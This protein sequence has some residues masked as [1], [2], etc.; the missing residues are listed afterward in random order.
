MILGY[1]YF[2][3]PPLLY[4]ESA[5]IGVNA[6]YQ[7]HDQLFSVSKDTMKAIIPRRGRLN[8]AHRKSGIVFVSDTQVWDFDGVESG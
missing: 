7:Q 8:F 4:L 3:T 1:P 2:R 5:I 6:T